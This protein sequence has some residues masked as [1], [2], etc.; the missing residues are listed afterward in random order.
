[1]FKP[2]FKYTHK[3]VNN[4]IEVT[5]ARELILNTYPKAPEIQKIPML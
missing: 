5:S 3:I 4:L 1:M 2:N